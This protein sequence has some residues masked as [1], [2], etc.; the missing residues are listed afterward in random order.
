MD[1]RASLLCLFL[2]QRV[3]L[4]LDLIIMPARSDRDNDRA[5]LLLRHQLR[6]LRRK[7]PHPP[8]ISRWENVSLLVL[9]STLT[10][11]MHTSRVRPGTLWVQ[12]VVLFQPE[13]VLTWHRELVR[14]TWT[15]RSRPARDRPSI[16]PD[17]EALLVRLAK[18]NPTW[19]Y[20]K[21]QGE[22][23]KLGY[24][25]GLSTIRD[26]LKRHHVPPAPQRSQRG[27][28]WC[29]FLRHEQDEML[30]C[31]C[32]TVDTVWLTRLYV[33]FCIELGSRRVHL[34]GCTTRPTAG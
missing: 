1:P 26:V 4:L 20:R 6:I 19:G 31:D 30:A 9:A 7:H 28:R 12:V 3:S 18:E 5:I 13:T 11:L 14:R 24:E 16:R 29:T 34:A 33:L 23:R 8:R 22:L 17:R 15:F 21:L 27:S 2:Q 25:I 10:T 32:F